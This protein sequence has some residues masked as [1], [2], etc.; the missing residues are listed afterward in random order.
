M[1]GRIKELTL[2]SFRKFIRE[3]GFHENLISKNLSG[4]VFTYSIRLGDNDYEINYIYV[5]SNQEIFLEHQKLWNQNNVNVFIAVGNDKSYIINAKF[6]PDKDNPLLKE[7]NLKSFDYGINS[8]GFEK[9]QLKEITKE[10]IDST[11]FFDF[12]IKNQ[13][14]KQEVDK[15]LLLNL[16]ALKNDLL[17][18]TNEDVVDLLILRSLFIKYLEDRKI[19][20]KNYLINIL[21]SG[22]PEKLIGAFEEIKK[23]NGDVFKTDTLTKTDIIQDYLKKL[24]VFFSSDY[25]SK[26]LSIFPYRFDQI[27][28]QLISHVYEA[29]LKSEKRKGKGIYYTPAFVVNFML[30]HTLKE[31]LK[32]NKGI[33]VFDPAVGSGAFLVE[34]FK[35]IIDSYNGEIDYQKKKEILQNQLFG[36]DIDEKALQIA[37]FSLYLAL[38]EKEDH[39]FIRKQIKESHPVLPSL[40][41]KN[42]IKANTITDN[43]FEDKMFD[44]IVSNPPWSLVGKADKA[45]KKALKDCF[46]YKAIHKR[47]PQRSQAFML[48]VQQWVGNDTRLG[49]IVNNSNFYSEFSKEFR[50]DLLE[51]YS[52]SQYYELSDYN[53]IL[54]KKRTIGEINKEQI[55]IGSSEPCA[56]LI[57]EEYKQKNNIIKY[58]SPKINHFSEHLEI[59]QYTSIDIFNIE[60][61]LLVENDDY[62]KIFV[63]GDWETL[64]LIEKI[65]KSKDDNLKYEFCEQGIQGQILPY[66]CIDMNKIENNNKFKKIYIELLSI[67]GRKFK[68]ITE[69]KRGLSE[70]LKRHAELKKELFKHIKEYIYKITIKEN[71]PIENKPFIQYSKDI[72]PFEIILEKESLKKFKTINWSNNFKRK[73]DEC[74]YYG[75]RFI[76]NRLPIPDDKLR[77]RCIYTNQ[78]I[79]YSDSFI[80]L[81]IKTTD[82][83][84]YFA[85]LNSLLTGF[86]LSNTASQWFKGNRNAIKNIEIRSFPFPFFESGSQ[87]IARVNQIL[88]SNRPEREKL[89]DIDQIVFDI[90]NLL[91]YEKEIIR[92]FYQI[93]VERTGKKRFVRPEDIKEYIKTFSYTFELMLAKDY[94]LNAAYKI[95]SNVGAIVCFN[96][97][98]KQQKE[99]IKQNN[100]LE[101]LHFVKKQQIQQAEIS[102]ILNEDKVKI[103]DQDRFYLIKSNLFKDWTKRQAIK[104]AREEIGLLLSS[105]P[106]DHDE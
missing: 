44:C 80:G 21:E 64:E 7:I 72:E 65:K 43:V 49:F 12:I 101:I 69:L 63:N 6:K 71:K 106:E 27:P 100:T 79:V 50:K 85:I 39:K 102:K 56:I 38:L 93:R 10:Y 76:I 48:K 9:E 19:Y 13:K 62:W 15:D 92:E 59:I 66:C 20:E 30:S 61:S 58:I 57:F 3:L 40:I 29:F 86:Y 42:L 67:K 2:N 88:K 81:K 22:S 4:N 104:D 90:Y 98:E 84:P 11:Y 73:R 47:Y 52:I 60:Q 31:K 89:N 28:I 5:S 46:I 75:E 91:D 83:F 16:I 1:E 14:N 77:L 37:A 34:S 103:Y 41:N 23:I 25:R 95:S 33:T 51:K 99:D 78:N 45:E 36:I 74:L 97:I 24:A 87:K 26:Q 105:L 18:N 53:P 35:M 68:N 82:H 94:A 55:E 70:S 54:F 32:K 8:K 17:T 96:L